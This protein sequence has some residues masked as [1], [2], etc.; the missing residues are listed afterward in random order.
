MAST[1]EVGC[2]G[3]DFESA[4][5]LA[6][7]SSKIFVPKSGILVSAGSEAEKLKFLPS[8]KVLTELGITIYATSG[9]ARYL[10]AHQIP[11]AEVSWPGEDNGLDPVEL[12][13]TK[14][15]D[16]VLNIPK[17]LQST[18]LTRGSLIRQAA[19]RF[20]CSLV[21][22]MEKMTS[23]VQALDYH[24]DFLRTHQVMVLPQYR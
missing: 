13:R 21:T 5:I 17:N 24:R 15:I 14:K 22:N 6:M 20:G 8:A 10:K 7:E 18:E 16:F 9:T 4:Y 1:G 2:I 23:Y 12:I 19:T 3:P 11:V